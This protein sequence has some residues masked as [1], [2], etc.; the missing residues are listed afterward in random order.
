MKV[1]L[2]QYVQSLKID[3]E[4][5]DVYLRAVLERDDWEI[6]S[7]IYD[8]Y[9]RGQVID[10]RTRDNKLWLNAVPIGYFCK[11]DL[12][13]YIVELQDRLRNAESD[14][15]MNNISLIAGK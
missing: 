14:T 10:I 9:Q 5:K 8:V 2:V 11:E 13:N 3:Q 4:E 1:G 7:N 12:L 6:T 15:F